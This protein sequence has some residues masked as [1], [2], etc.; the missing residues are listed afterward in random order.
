MARL[1]LNCDLGEEEPLDY[2]KELLSLVDAANI[3][4]GFH[5][6]SAAKTH[7]SLKLA[8]ESGVMIGAHPGLASDGG[9][10]NTLPNPAGFRELL[11]TQIGQFQQMAASLGGQPAYIKL[12]GSLYHAVEAHPELAQV[13]LDYLQAQPLPLAVFS[14]ANG[15]FASVAE[16]IGIQV[17]HEV[18]IDRNYQA[19]GS[20][21]PRSEPDAVLSESDAITRLL[22]WRD[23]GS[24]QTRTGDSI[25]LKADTFCVHGDSPGALQMIRKVR[26]IFETP[27]ADT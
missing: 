10:G 2:T 15:L 20:L 27:P 4:C 26:T 1:I 19:D 17:Y 12:H 23:Y 22:L 11:D 5:A 6:G 3:G 13:F 14:R 9:R 24:M 8:I 16:A 21:V 7:E 25:H 18:F